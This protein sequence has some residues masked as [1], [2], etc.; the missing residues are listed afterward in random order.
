MNLMRG[1]SFM[2]RSI[3]VLDD[4]HKPVIKGLNNLSITGG[5]ASINQDI[6]RDKE[7]KFFNISPLKGMST[8]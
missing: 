8:K 6:Q 1:N 3:T 4:D 7:S 2:D 5:A